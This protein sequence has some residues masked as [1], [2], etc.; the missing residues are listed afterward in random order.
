MLL[1]IVILPPNRIRKLVGQAVVKSVGDFKYRY[2]ID[3]KHLIP[4]L[5]LFHININKRKLAALV[6]VV[7]KNISNYQPVEIST[8]NILVDGNGVFILLSNRKSLINLNRKMVRYCYPL[9]DGMI[10][11][12]SK[13]LPNKLEKFNRKTYGT[14]YNIGKAFQP[15]FT[16]VKLKF[17][18]DAKIVGEE[19]KNIHFSFM[20]NTIAICQINDYSQVTKVLKTFKLG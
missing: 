15:H 4:H 8:K 19:M 9:R 2:I 7:K 12:M 5:S 11:W 16:V 13:R 6:A 10:P 17:D 18:T 20:G 1:D 14:Y 3:N